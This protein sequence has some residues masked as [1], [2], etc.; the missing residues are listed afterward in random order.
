MARRHSYEVAVEWTGDRGSGTRGYRTYGRDHTVVADGRPVL[1]GSADPFFRG[2]PERWN[3]ELLLVAAL[4]EC[5]LLSYLSLCARAGVVVREY[6]DRAVGAMAEEGSGGRF[7]EVLL[8][9]EVHVDDPAVID[10][11]VGLH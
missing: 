2:D 5:H 8:R 10:R 6:R 3:P 9:P 11:A 1:L 7:V 4:S